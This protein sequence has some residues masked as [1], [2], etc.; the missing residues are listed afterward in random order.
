M[1]SSIVTI[2]FNQIFDNEN[3]EDYLSRMN[4][5]P[6][7]LLIDASTH[8]L[9]F[10]YNDS[11]VI[12][13]RELLSNWFSDSNNILAN[14][15]NDKINKYKKSKSVEITIINAKASLTL[16]EKVLSTN[17]NPPEISNDE[18]EVLLFKVY[19]AINETLNKNDE[20]V[21]SSINDNEEYPRLICMSIATSL[22]TFDISNY[23]ILAVFVAQTIKSIFLFEF[24]ENRADCRKMLS[25]FYRKFYVENY[26]E[27]LRRLLSISFTILSAK[28]TGK[29]DLILERDEHFISNTAFLDK[30]TI[31]LLEK[32]DDDIDY[33]NLRSNPLIKIRDNKYRIIFPL[34]AIEKN[35][36]GLY[37]LLKEINDNY[38]ENQRINL[39]QIFTYDFSERHILYT[40]IEQIYKKKYV[41]F[42]GDNMATPGSPDYYIRNGS[43][44]F[45]FESKDILINASIKESYNFIEYERAL[46]EKLY[47]NKGKIKTSPKAVRQL[48]NFCRILLK[49]EF[50][51]DLNFKP[52]SAK[53]Y[54]IIILHNRQLDILGL[55]NLINIWFQ[56]EIDMINDGNINL[57][58][59][60]MPTIINIDTLILLYEKLL[61][62]KIK[63]EDIIDDYQL[64]INDK[65]LKNKTF[66]TKEKLLS[67]IQDQLVSFNYF[68]TKKYGW[69][70]PRL[71]E[72]KGFSVLKQ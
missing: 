38:E 53:I 39:R 20:L 46:K 72:E 71:F 32:N 26:K 29:I 45:I 9:S 66:K 5:I 2:G 19:L 59:I 70:I 30:F 62:G 44:I 22:P 36:N 60:R 31:N 3:Y 13:H 41:K 24:L 16:F 12:N 49:G 40:I 27:F 68:V 8:L 10:N 48:A 34:F 43:K 42:K 55:N 57:Q 35:F 50:K 65:S 25:D 51:E 67:A 52:K 6:K 33:L 21:I 69:D 4:D 58:H 15:I 14:E 1:V 56:Q 63:I 23:D 61:M 11:F 64:F 47:F 37:F 17:S 28:K 54:P 7:S 18:F